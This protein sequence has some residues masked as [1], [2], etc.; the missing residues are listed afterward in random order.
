MVIRNRVNLFRWHWLLPPPVSLNSKTTETVKV[1]VSRGK[2][3]TESQRWCATLE[4]GCLHSR[5]G[6]EAAT[7]KTVFRAWARA[8]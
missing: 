4:D 3:T 7:L 8:G 5:G 6:I 1:M 2:Y